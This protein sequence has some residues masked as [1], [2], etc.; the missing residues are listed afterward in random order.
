MAKHREEEVRRKRKVIEKMAG[1]VCWLAWE[2]IGLRGHVDSGPLFNSDGSF[3]MFDGHLRSLTRYSINSTRELDTTL[4]KNFVP[5]GQNIFVDGSDIAVD[6]NNQ[7]RE[8][9]RVATYASPESQNKMLRIAH[10]ITLSAVLDRIRRC[11][12]FSLLADE[13]TDISTRE[14]LSICVRT[15]QNGEVSYLI[16]LHVFDWS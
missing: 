10:D 12:T 5:E 13:S 7:S 4:L 14:Q 3:S 9:K 2:G 6:S 11:G 8:K 15:F 16:L 1:S